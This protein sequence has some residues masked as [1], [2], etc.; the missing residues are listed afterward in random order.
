MISF[1]KR[2]LG[3]SSSNNRS[4]LRRVDENSDEE[5]DTVILRDSIPSKSVNKST[6]NSSR[7]GQSTYISKSVSTTFESTREI[8]PQKYAVT[9]SLFVFDDDFEGR[10]SN[11][12]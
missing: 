8:I 12:I 5:D 4:K 11:V 2:S 7:D 3:N 1:K 9:I 10:S 6:N